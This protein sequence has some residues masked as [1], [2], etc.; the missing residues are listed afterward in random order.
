VGESCWRGRK[1]KR[2]CREDE[3]DK[4]KRLKVEREERES[5]IGEGRRKVDEGK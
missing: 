1:D 5:S 4:G 3:G 2:V